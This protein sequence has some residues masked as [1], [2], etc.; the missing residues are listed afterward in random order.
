M[1]TIKHYRLTIKA[2]KDESG[3][4]RS[5][6][7]APERGESHHF[8]YL[9]GQFLSFRIPCE[10]GEISRCY[11]LSSTPGFD[12][13]MTVCVKRVPGGRGSNWFNDTLRVGARIDAQLPSGR[14]T[15]RADGDQAPLFLVAGGSGITPCISLLKQALG[16]SQRPVKLLYANQHQ[17]SII[18]REQLAKLSARYPEQFSCKHWLDDERGLLSP[19][20]IVDEIKGWKSAQFYICGPEP[21]MDMAEQALVEHCGED[22][23]ILTERFVSSANERGDDTEHV[24]VNEAGVAVEQFRLTLDGHE[25]ALNVEANQTLL[26]AALAAGIDAPHSCIE[27]HCGTCMSVLREGEVQMTSSR[28]LSKRNIEKGYVLA[29]QSRPGSSSPIWLDFDL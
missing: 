7:L 26:E 10:S 2:I 6:V 20:S 24:A 21:L 15:L 22:T 18:Y 9:P 3:E 17:G 16:E 5:F 14:F 27:G 29:C 25:Y 4:A 8:R 19:Q 11:S 13:D 1:A 23:L 12:P 28:A